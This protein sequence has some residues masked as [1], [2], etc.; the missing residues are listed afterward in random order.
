MHTF[1]Q[2]HAILTHWVHDLDPFVIQFSNMGPFEGIRWY[3]LAYLGGFLIAA[4]LLY[5][6]HKKNK[7]PLDFDQQTTLMCSIMI[8]VLV[9]GRLGYMLLYALPE[10]LHNPLLFFRIWGGGMASHGGFIGVILA[11][12]WFSRKYRYNPWM[13]ADAVATVVPPGFFLEE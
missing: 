7:F 10:F 8:G 12:Y 13:I 2:I 5:F 11:M 6:Y 3:G 9:G 4:G 1:I